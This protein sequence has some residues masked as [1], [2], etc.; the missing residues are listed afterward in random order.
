MLSNNS[1]LNINKLGLIELTYLN[2]IVHKDGTSILTL[3]IQIAK[4]QIIIPTVS[5]IFAT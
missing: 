3:I 2:W 5:A 4:P 1:L